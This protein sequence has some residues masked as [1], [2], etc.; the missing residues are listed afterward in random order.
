MV[1]SCQEYASTH[2]NA[3]TI[4][5]RQLPLVA[6]IIIPILQLVKRKPRDTEQFIQLYNGCDIGKAKWRV[7]TIIWPSQANE[8]K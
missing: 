3:E 8:N 5:M 6:R 2:T 4:P 7:K 1:I